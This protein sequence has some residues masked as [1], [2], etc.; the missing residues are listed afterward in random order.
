MPGDVPA[1][2]PNPLMHPCMLLAR[3]TLD[4][5]HARW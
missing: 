4:K 2:C 3:I 1:E 5:R